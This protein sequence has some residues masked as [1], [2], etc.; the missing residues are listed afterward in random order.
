MSQQINLYNPLF[1]KKEKHFSARTMAHAL[2][3]VVLAI[4]AVFV[5]S[6]VQTRSAER[7]ATQYRDQLT[8]EQARLVALTRDAAGAARSKA[9]ESEVAQ[10]DAQIKVREQTLQALNTGE[11]GNTEGFSG[12]LA[13]LGREALPGVWLTR[14][15]IDDAGNGLLVEGRA[16]RAELLPAYLKALSREAMMRGRRVTEMKVSAASAAAG[17]NAPARFVEFSLAAPL[18]IR[19]S[20]AAAGRAQ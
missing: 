13:A 1:L 17:Q 3:V 8:R 15:R 14:V 11:L 2:A 19:E 18:E 6:L 10:L 4:A 20:A 5:A 12:F 9:L 7:L 16:L